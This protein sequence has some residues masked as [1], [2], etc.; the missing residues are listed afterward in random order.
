MIAFRYRAI[1][2]TGGAVEG[3]VEAEDRRGAL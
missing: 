1:Q 3:V 2:G